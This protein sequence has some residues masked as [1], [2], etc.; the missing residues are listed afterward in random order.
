M[1]NKK[2]LHK[3]L[4][5]IYIIY[6]AALIVG[7]AASFVPDF[8]RGW[9][10][11]QNTLAAEIPQGGIRSYFVSAPVIRTASEPV[12]IDNLPTN[13]T[14]TV[15]R[16]DLQVTVNE[17][18]TIGNAFKVMG[19]NGYSYLLMVVTG[20]SYL[21]ILVLIAL[22]INSLRKSIRDEQPLR[23]SNILRTRAIGILILV[24]ELSEALMKYINNQEAARLLEGTSFEVVTTFPLSYWN[25]IVGILFLFMAEVF[26]LST[27]LSEEQKLTI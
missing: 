18:Y 3:H 23:H 19:N 6:F 22:I 8:S 16:L 17:P 1:H 27:Q 25:V 24:A 12:V 11:A 26:S 4:L 2:R 14:P 21:T 5:V 7:F 13:I 15:G 20:L 10:S 9:R